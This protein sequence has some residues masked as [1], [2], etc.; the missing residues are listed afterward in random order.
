LGPSPPIRD[1]WDCGV[2]D[3]EHEGGETERSGVLVLPAPMD[4]YL[5][6]AFGLDGTT[7]DGLERTNGPRAA[8]GLDYPSV[9]ETLRHLES[10]MGLSTG[11]DTNAD[12]APMDIDTILSTT[13]PQRLLSGFGETHCWGSLNSNSLSSLPFHLSTPEP[14]VLRVSSLS[15]VVTPGGNLTL[16]YSNLSL[17]PEA[18]VEVRPQTPRISVAVA[19]SGLTP[20]FVE[21]VSGLTNPDSAE[22]REKVFAG[23]SL[24]PDDDGME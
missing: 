16:T 21:S 7:H 2:D 1:D 12:P 10:A 14:Q 5:D 15:P 6:F 23:P 17:P 13:I 18:P 24:F 22:I 11:A 3:F 20:G 19:G 8:T 9:S 4:P